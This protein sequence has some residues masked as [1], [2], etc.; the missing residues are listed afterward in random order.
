MGELRCW[1]CDRKLLEFEPLA[2]VLA[3][4][5]RIVCRRCGALNR[6]ELTAQ[7]VRA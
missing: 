2:G 5:V 1:R 6:A 3:A 4:V 7:T